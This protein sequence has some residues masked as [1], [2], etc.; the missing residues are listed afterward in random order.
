MPAV[1][2]ADVECD[3]V[4]AVGGLVVGVDVD[5]GEITG[6]QDHEVPSGTEVRLS[7]HDRRRRVRR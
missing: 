3:V 2:N 5:V 7:R 4:L 6:S 1:G